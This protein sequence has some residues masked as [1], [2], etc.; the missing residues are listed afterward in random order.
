MALYQ[1]TEGPEGIPVEVAFP[2]ASSLPS[3][4]EVS[5]RLL[6]GIERMASVVHRGTLSNLS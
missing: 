5:V 4:G 3:R 1:E 6:E 2:L